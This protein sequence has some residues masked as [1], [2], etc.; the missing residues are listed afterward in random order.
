M[1]EKSH[2]LALQ[3]EVYALRLICAHLAIALEDL[4]RET[5]P[6]RSESFLKKHAQTIFNNMLCS[7]ARSNRVNELGLDNSDALEFMEAFYE[8]AQRYRDGLLAT[9]Q[10]KPPAELC[11]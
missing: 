8:T 10:G 6:G 11:M 1:Q 9:Q 4:H 5:Q 3:G 7:N 2:T